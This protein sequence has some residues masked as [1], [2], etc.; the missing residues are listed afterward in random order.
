MSEDERPDDPPF[1]VHTLASRH[2]LAPSD[3][4]TTTA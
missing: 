4:H 1:E 3:S 2:D